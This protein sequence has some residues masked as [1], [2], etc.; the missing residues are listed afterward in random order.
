MIN[1]TTTVREIKAKLTGSDNDNETTKY[2]RTA[3]RMRA[4]TKIQG[5]A[6]LNRGRANERQ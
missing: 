6:N 1:K 5:Q 2:V 4:K 3:L